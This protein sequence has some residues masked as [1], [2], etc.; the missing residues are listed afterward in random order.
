VLAALDG[1]LQNHSGLVIP[2]STPTAEEWPNGH[3]L[4][5]EERPF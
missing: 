4:E 2:G 1:T 3:L 5:A